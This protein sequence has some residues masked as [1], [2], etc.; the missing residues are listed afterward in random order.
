MVRKQPLEIDGY[1]ARFG[2][3]L[4]SSL[5]VKA[6]GDQ[7]PVDVQPFSSCTRKLL[8]EL[9]EQVACEPSDLIVDLGCG[10]G[11]VGLWL[12]SRLGCR[13]IG[14]D[15]SHPG[16]EIAAR[17]ATERGL[18]RVARFQ[19]GQ[20]EATG[21]GDQSANAVVSVDALPFAV[22]V[23]A[24]LAEIHRILRPGG[25]LVFTTREVRP[26]SERAKKLGPAWSR[27][28]DGNGF[29]SVQV[30][31]RNGVSALWQALY[32]QWIENER[33]LRNELPDE[34]VDQLL[35]EVKEVGGKLGD[36]RPWLLITAVTVKMHGIGPG[37]SNMSE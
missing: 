19:V 29:R 2:K 15:C 34:I 9:A 13:I 1:A 22:D 5:W 25:R 31:H 11:G 35:A 17:R 36:G 21:L 18:D 6:W 23:D 30:Q 8:E 12:A 4:F 3:P 32:N 28:L 16:V 14:V 37:K 27:V 26:G 24:A 7:Y 20:F 10:A 33:A